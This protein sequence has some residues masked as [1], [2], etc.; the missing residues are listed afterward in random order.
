QRGGEIAP[1]S[2]TPP[3]PLPTEAVAWNKAAP[4]A[5]SYWTRCA[6]DSRV[7]AAFQKICAENAALLGAQLT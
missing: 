7:S 6:T 1:Q 2:Y 5:A 4:A 3:L